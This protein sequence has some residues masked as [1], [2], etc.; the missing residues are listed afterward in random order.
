MPRRHED[1]YRQGGDYRRQRDH[2]NDRGYIDRGAD[3]VRS[4][5]GD[6]EAEARRRMD[7]R[8]D[9]NPDQSEWNR[10]QNRQQPNWNRDQSNWRD[11]SN[12]DQSAS[13]PSR[14]WNSGA[15]WRNEGQWRDEGQWR[16]QRNRSSE[17]APGDDWD[18]DQPI[19][20]RDRDDRGSSM[21]PSTGGL[22]SADEARPEFSGASAAYGS[23]TAR[24]QNYWGRGPKGYQRAD[25]RIH[26]D[27]CDRL[28]YSDVDAD[29]I[30]VT[31][32]NGEVT[33]SGS[34]RDRWDKRRAEDV[35]EAVSGV[36]DVHN[37]IR[38][39]RENRGDQGIGHSDLSQSSQPGTVLGINPTKDAQ[40]TNTTPTVNKRS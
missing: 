31:V 20:S 5:F 11:R 34:V 39:S 15:D 37:H 35:V 27:V 29:N 23:S 19:R 2:A 25:N 16:N 36:K 17:W 18:R 9:W 14:E 6:E 10:N 1:R 21:R 12:W 32:Q 13:H 28:T 30:E 8:R 26:E 3:E 40:V 4:W 33:L 22:W 7:E 24:P 38:V